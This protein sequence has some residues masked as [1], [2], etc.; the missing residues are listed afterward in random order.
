MAQLKARARQEDVPGAGRR[1]RSSATVGRIEAPIGRDPQHRTRMA[2]V[3]DGRPATTGY[4]VRER[5]PRL[6]PAR[7]RPRHRPD[8]PDP[9]P[10]RRHRPPGGGRS[11]L[12]HRDVAPRPRGPGA[13]LPARLAA[14]ARVAGGRPPH[15]RRRRRCR[16]SS[17]PS[18]SGFAAER[19][20]RAR[21]EDADP[22][23]SDRREAGVSRRAGGRCQRLRDAGASGAHARDHLRAVRGRQGHDHRGAAGRGHV[24]DVP[25]RRDLHDAGA[26]GPAR[27]TA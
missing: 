13:A 27:S 14:R 7:A 24:P 11:G 2:V 8:A 4:R 3:P 15:P 19:G 22:H 16:R 26:G 12:R 18:W 5:L 20:R 25:L 10:P 17:S 9:R 23:D 6:D 21:D 1:A